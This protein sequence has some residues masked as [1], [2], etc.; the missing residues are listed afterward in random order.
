M[1]PNFTSLPNNITLT[2]EGRTVELHCIAVGS[3]VPTIQ[4]DKD[5]VMDGFTSKRYLYTFVT[6]R[7]LFLIILLNSF[8]V[9]PN[10]TL[11]IQNVQL[12]DEGFYGCT[13]GN[14]GGFKRAEFRLVV[15][16]I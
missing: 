16:G 6:L 4:W 14:A 9:H 11:T 2:Q 13:A 10:G 12:E 8:T 15:Q 7:I 5:S 1:S 3:P